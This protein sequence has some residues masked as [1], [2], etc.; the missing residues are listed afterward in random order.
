MLLNDCINTNLTSHLDN[1]GMKF[2]FLRIRK[3]KK[4]IP[5]EYKMNRILTSGSRYSA[6]YN[7]GV[8]TNS[9]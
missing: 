2:R 1:F 9:L 3:A 4:I 8:I 5:K 6:S 7:D